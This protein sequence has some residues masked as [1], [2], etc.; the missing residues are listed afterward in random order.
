MDSHRVGAIMCLPALTHNRANI[1][2]N[3]RDGNTPW[4]SPSMSSAIFANLINSTIKMI[5]AFTMTNP[6]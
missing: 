6:T 3:S 5:W 1:I 4:G 2:Q